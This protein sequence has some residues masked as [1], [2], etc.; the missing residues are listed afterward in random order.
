M[1]LLLL[2]FILI[3]GLFLPSTALAYIDGGTGSLI[4]QTLVGLAAGVWIFVKVFWH[5]ILGAFSKSDP[6]E[7]NATSENDRTAG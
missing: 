3:A 7:S 2:L 6:S 1:K 5:K 4:L